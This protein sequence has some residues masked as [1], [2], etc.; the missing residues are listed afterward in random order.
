MICALRDAQYL[1]INGT[2]ALSE[3]KGLKALMPAAVF[4]DHRED[5]GPHAPSGQAMH[6]K[7]GSEV[8]SVG[9]TA[10]PHLG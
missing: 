8:V 5:G 4:W 3:H 10:Q 1:A 6:G 9:C 7:A 2:H